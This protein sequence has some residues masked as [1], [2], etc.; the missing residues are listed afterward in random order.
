MDARDDDFARIMEWNG[1]LRL[2]A[3]LQASYVECLQEHGFDPDQSFQLVRDWS[4]R[5]WDW[6]VREAFEP[7]PLLGH[8]TIPGVTV[9]DDGTPVAAMPSVPETAPDPHDCGYLI[10]PR[11][12]DHQPVAP[13]TELPEP[14][15]APVDSS[16]PVP[17]SMDGRGQDVDAGWNGEVLT[18]EQLWQAR[19]ARDDGRSDGGREAA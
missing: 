1:R 15:F 18:I 3:Q 17:E 10:E 8:M 11:P 4:G 14:P 7:H 16:T 6:T 19:A 2:L 12:E 5:A 9:L 13:T